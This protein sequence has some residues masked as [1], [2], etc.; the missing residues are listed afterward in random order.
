MKTQRKTI[1]KT[2]VNTNMFVHVSSVNECH[3]IDTSSRARK[4]V[5][6]RSRQNVPAGPRRHPDLEIAWYPERY[7]RDLPWDSN[8]KRPT[9]S[10]AIKFNMALTGYASF[11][12]PPH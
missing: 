12:L 2:V 7:L 3:K 10:N 4:T 5:H 1:N 9:S 6:M 11:P 8:S